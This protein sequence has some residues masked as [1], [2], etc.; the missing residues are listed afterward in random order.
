[1][2]GKRDVVPKLPLITVKR[3]SS[4]I[5]LEKKYISQLCDQFPLKAKL[6]TAPKDR[7]NL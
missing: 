4:E 1:M 5:Y 7:V 2:T 3:D 6:S